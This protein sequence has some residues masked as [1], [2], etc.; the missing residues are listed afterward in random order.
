MFGLITM[1]RVLRELKAEADLLEA[2]ALAKEKRADAKGGDPRLITQAELLRE[3]GGSLRQ[4]AWI[5]EAPRR[6]RS[7]AL[8]QAR[9][10]VRRWFGLPVEVP[11]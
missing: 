5:L 9:W 4:F 8:C 1:R 2:D 6:N 7:R 11:K 10:R 3:Y